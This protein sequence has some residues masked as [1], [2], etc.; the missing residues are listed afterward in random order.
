MGKGG[1][2]LWDDSALVSAF[3]DAVS[4]YKIKHNQAGGAG[5]A[6]VNSS[7]VEDESKEAR[8]HEQ[9]DDDSKALSTKTIEMAETSTVS[10]VAQNYCAEASGLEQ[11]QDKPTSYVNSQSTE[12]YNFLL[13]KYYEI[14]DQRQ[15]SLQQLYQ[16]C[17]WSYE[18]PGHSTLTSQE[19]QTYAAHASNSTP[20]A[21]YC[22]YGCQSSVTPPSCCVGGNCIDK[23][24]DAA[25]SS[26]DQ[27]STSLQQPDV[28]KTAMDTAEKA[29][30]SLRHDLGNDRS[31]N[32]SNDHVEEETKPE[33]DLSEVLQA[34]YSAGFYT[35][36]YLSEQSCARKQHD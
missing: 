11:S 17:G 29:L 13:C 28:V 26:N 4:K 6:L 22:P 2:D 34:W 24:F 1:N 36:K 23:N 12:D 14:E 31:P 7:A 35:G 15:K 30:S 9:A 16:F 3:N 20:T 8:R 27:S 5:S 10:P 33:T 25:R 32:M 21:F 19:H 18:Y